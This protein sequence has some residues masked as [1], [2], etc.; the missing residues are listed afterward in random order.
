VSGGYIIRITRVHCRY[1]TNKLVRVVDSCD[2][3]VSGEFLARLGVAAAGKINKGA[4][5]VRV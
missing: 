1:Q 5:Y 4:L 3:L 2:L